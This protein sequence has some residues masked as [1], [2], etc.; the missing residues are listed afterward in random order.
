[1]RGE[2]RRRQDSI[3]DLQMVPRAFELLS[4]DGFSMKED[5]KMQGK[6]ETVRTMPEGIWESSRPKQVNGE[7]GSCDGKD[8]TPDPSLTVDWQGNGYPGQ[9]RSRTASDNS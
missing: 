7:A 5:E 1:M 6:E 3:P 4:K 8:G 9:P 2:K